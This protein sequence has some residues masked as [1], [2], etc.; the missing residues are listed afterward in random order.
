[1]CDMTCD[2]TIYVWH[3]VWHDYIC[4]TWRD[5]TI[6]VWHG[7]YMC[8]MAC[9]MTYLYERHGALL[10]HVTHINET[11]VT[12]Q[13]AMSHAKHSTFKAEV[14]TSHVTHTH[15]SWGTYQ[16]A[17]SQMWNFQG[18]GTHDP[19]R[20]TEWVMG[21]VSGRHITHVSESCMHCHA[22]EWV[23]S[24]V[25]MSHVT[26]MNESRGT[27]EWDM[28]HMWM[29]HICTVTH[30]NEHCHRWWVMPYTWMSHGTCT[31]APCH[32]SEWVTSYIHMSHI[33][34]RMSNVP[35]VNQSC[36]KKKK[37]VGQS[38]ASQGFEGA[39]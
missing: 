9:D 22:C 10:C 33:T 26:H 1:M 16:C 6:Y 25:W 7:I 12:Y 17:V 13:R 11:W 19:Y 36:M 31:N 23:L 39:D 29:S 21:H 8:D 15:E 38:R 34:H 3:G 20:S 4:V 2:M 37:K 18:R 27:H 5:L 28:S 14:R 30:A 35:H 24:Q 32:T